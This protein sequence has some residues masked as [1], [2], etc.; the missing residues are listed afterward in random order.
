[1]TQ[2]LFDNEVVPYTAVTT[3]ERYK[4][5]YRTGQNLTN[6]FSFSNSG[7]NGGFD[8]SIANTK[9]TAI[10]E[11]SDFTRRNITL[12]FT[13]NISKWIN[14]SG[15]INYSNEYYK[16]A[17]MG[18]GNQSA[19]VNTIATMSNTMPLSLMK[20]YYQDPVT[21]KEIIWSR[22]LPRVNP[23]FLL[24]NRFDD[25]KRDRVLGNVAIKFNVTKEIYIQGRIA[26]DFY[27]RQHDYNSPTGRLDAQAAPAGYVDGSYNR[28]HNTFRER[29]YDILIG[30]QHKFGNIGV[31]LT[32]GGNQMFRSMVSENQGA[33]DFIQPGLYTIMNG[34]QK[35]ASHGLTERAVNSIYG[36]VKFLIKTIYF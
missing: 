13:Q 36:A 18:V 17:P 5:F 2:T 25:N 8:L 20:K 27:S 33:Q 11:N 34:R 15:N 6:T 14:V 19:P 22:F 23:Y 21:G 29:N 4:E 26:Q 1:M 7:D 30:A 16:N 32:A 3:K 12:G 28:V 24:Y 9:N 35:S 10:L 31:N